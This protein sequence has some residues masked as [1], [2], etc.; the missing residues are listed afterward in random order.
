MTIPAAT[1][2][3]VHFV[4]AVGRRSLNSAQAN[5]T[6][7]TNWPQFGFTPNHKGKNRYENVLSTATVGDLDE[8][9]R[10][11]NISQVESTPAVVNGIIYVTFGDGSIR[12]FDEITGAQ[13][14]SYATTAP[15]SMNSSPAVAN[16]IVYVGSGDHY[17][18]A[19]DAVTGALKWRYA[20]G[21]VVYSSPTVVNG[22]VYFGS[23]D[24]NM[25]ALNATTGA[26][27]WSFATGGYIYSSPMIVNGLGF[28]GSSD[29]SVYC[30]DAVT[31]EKIRGLP[32]GGIVIA[33]PVIA[34]G[35]VCFGSED[36]YFYAFDATYGNP[37]WSVGV[38][39]NIDSS[40]VVSGGAIFFADQKGYVRSLT[41]GGVFRWST[42][43]PSQG[44]CYSP[45]SVANG[46]VYVRD[47]HYTYA[48]DQNSGALLTTMPV[49]SVYGG[50]AVVDGAV[51]AGDDTDGVL[52]RYTP[53]GLL[54]NFVAPRPEPM[55]LRPHPLR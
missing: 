8:A 1:R 34:G 16:G 22:I 17:L 7:Q 19:L 46:V 53:N 23:Y 27:V 41:T 10:T 18:Y 42:R 38:L 29:G 49:A 40:A 50:V 51:F 32:T 14:W 12:A 21:N 55:Q 15:Y 28:V 13:K 35:L 44:E 52:T 30:F 45:L 11:P 2:P 26:L 47:N 37:V 20:T 24:A 25:Y 3:G 6:V 36:G 33:S 54:S 4:T 39:A 9:W 48:L 31:G 43:L 5:F